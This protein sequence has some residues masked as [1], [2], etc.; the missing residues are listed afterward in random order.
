MNI[1]TGGW[2]LAALLWRFRSGE[3]KREEESGEKV[4]T[5]SKFP[6]IAKLLLDKQYLS[7]KRERSSV[8]NSNQ[9]QLLKDWR[10]FHSF[11]RKRTCGN[12]FKHQKK[13]FSSR[14]VQLYDESDLSS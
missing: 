14:S 6:E 10:R 2:T 12:P 8:K 7:R 13:F 11:C 1:S 4:E 9:T 3:K 5:Y